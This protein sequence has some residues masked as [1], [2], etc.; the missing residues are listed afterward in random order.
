MHIY[1]KYIYTRLYLYIYF[2]YSKT[3]FNSILHSKQCSVFTSWL[4]YRSNLFVSLRL[5]RKTLVCVVYG[6]SQQVMFV[7]FEYARKSMQKQYINRR[8]TISVNTLRRMELVKWNHRFMYYH[9][10]RLKIRQK[11]LL[12]K[13]L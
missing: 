9:Q 2:P 4:Y 10:Y 1:L 12:N 7:E 13:W 5:Y 11:L 3:F 8:Q 6:F